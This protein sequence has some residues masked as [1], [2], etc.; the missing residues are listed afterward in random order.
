MKI[1]NRCGYQNTDNS[2]KCANCLVDLHWAKVNLGKFTGTLDDTKRIGEEERKLRG[3]EKTEDMNQPDPLETRAR[4]IAIGFFGW[5]IF[6]NLWFIGML[7]FGLS[8]RCSNFIDIFR[9]VV[10]LWLP[11]VL[12]LVIVPRVVFAKKRIWIGNGIVAA[13]IINIVINIGSW[14]VLIF[15]VGAFPLMSPWAYLA[16]PFPLGMYLFLSTSLV[17]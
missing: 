8:F 4:D 15:G 16:F 14:I 3:V 6:H 17:G 9:W 1:C 5:I 2:K 10:F 11:L 13:I 7:K 12:P